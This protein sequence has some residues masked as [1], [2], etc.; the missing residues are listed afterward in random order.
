MIL[1]TV[2]GHTSVIPFHLSPFGNLCVLPVYLGHPYLSSTFNKSFF[3][4]LKKMVQDFLYLI[5]FV[6]LS[7]DCPNKLEKIETSLINLSIAPLI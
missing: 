3:C 6:V 2:W 7:I 4:L 1:W 5:Q